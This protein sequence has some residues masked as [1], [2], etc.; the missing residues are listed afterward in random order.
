MS[1]LDGTFDGT[2]YLPLPEF[3]HS[4]HSE[5]LSTD[6]T[7]YDMAS[8][9]ASERPDFLF[10][11][12][13]VSRAIPQAFASVVTNFLD[14]HFNA[15]RAHISD[16]R[17][18]GPCSDKSIPT[19]L[20]VV[21][22]K[23]SPL[24]CL[25]NS[26]DVLAVIKVGEN[27]ISS[28]LIYHF[29]ESKGLESRGSYRIS[30][31]SDLMELSDLMEIVQVAQYHIGKRQGKELLNWNLSFDLKLPDNNLFSG[32]EVN[33]GSRNISSP[34]QNLGCRGRIS[35]SGLPLTV[36]VY[37][38]GAGDGFWQGDISHWQLGAG[39]QLLQ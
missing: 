18:Y 22:W 3:Q 27:A 37:E 19:Q 11:A 20:S 25:K 7:L 26:T 24:D 15:A 39:F 17:V 2:D 31:V 13:A 34:F 10:I 36:V 1:F 9:A 6:K 4:Y 21:E 12:T 28:H 35:P 33:K 23:Q 5:T 16:L 29:V 8:S 14:T 38:N 32:N 30:K